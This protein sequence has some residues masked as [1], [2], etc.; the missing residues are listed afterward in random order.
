METATQEL[1]V[2][3][4]EPPDAQGYL[5]I[6]FDKNI[7]LP[8]NCTKWSSENEGSKRI[9]TEYLPSEDT[10]TFMYDQDVVVKM[11]WKVVEVNIKKTRRLKEF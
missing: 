1:V 2:M 4:I 9:L 3:T 11:E 7:L 10:L 6:K 5:W 8:G